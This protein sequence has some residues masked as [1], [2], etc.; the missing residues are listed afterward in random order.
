MT[1]F[2]IREAVFRYGD[3]Q[4]LSGISL[5]IERG[6]R[7]ALVGA[8]GSGKS[9]L[10]RLLDGLEF[11]QEGSV[12]FDGQLLS[13][14][15]LGDDEV[16]LDFRRRV[17]FVFQNAEVQL[18]S[19][20]VYEELAFGPLQLGWP[21]E[22][23][24]ARIDEMLR[25][26]DLQVL[27]DRP[28]YRLSGGEKRRVALAAVLITDPEVLLLDEPTAMLD[29]R[30]QA[31]IIDQLVAWAGTGRTVV[32]ATHDLDVIEEIADRCVVLESGGIAA[33][34]R[35]AAILGS[36]ELLLRTG[37]LHAH[38]HHHADGSSHTH[39]HVHRAHEHG[40]E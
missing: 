18:F 24:R 36:T 6:T 23:I 10:L 28:P 21:Q 3:V 27:R 29:P 35:P 5:D 38:R 12:E 11:P 1:L 20:T 25:R 34:D 31:F 16:A 7:V 22:E 8:N 32:T 15:W 30:S 37:L 40:H 2:S 39:P 19:A 33:D 14:R 26:A 13:E 9:T 17:G 4:A